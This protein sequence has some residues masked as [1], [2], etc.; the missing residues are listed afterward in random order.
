MELDLSRDA[1]IGSG[2]WSSC[3]VQQDG[4]VV[5]KSKD[6]C[7]KLMSKEGWPKHR[8][9]PKLKCIRLETDTEE[10]L[11]QMERLEIISKCSEVYIKS[12]LSKRQYRWYKVLQEIDML[13]GSIERQK[14][15]LTQKIP[16]E[17]HREMKRIFEAL[18]Y[19]WSL[20]GEAN[21]ECQDFNLAIKD[22]YVVLLDCFYPK[23]GSSTGELSHPKEYEFK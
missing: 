11:Y 8:T 22:G 6:F 2:S 10:P 19:I 16:K 18:E 1:N 21:F 9:W 15:T 5:I 4:T 20:E 7:K 12:N 23:G 17:F 3:F 13:G 14:T